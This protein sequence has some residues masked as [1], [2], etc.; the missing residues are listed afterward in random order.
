MRT[1]TPLRHK[2]EFLQGA[3]LPQVSQEQLQA[4]CPFHRIDSR[5]AQER[6]AAVDIR[7]RLLPPQVA[8]LITPDTP[9]TLAT[10]TTRRRLFFLRRAF[11]ARVAVVSRV[12]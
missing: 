12:T 7:E 6:L 10:A 2:I 11:V 8:R 4:Q 9:V 1:C 3:T 5:L